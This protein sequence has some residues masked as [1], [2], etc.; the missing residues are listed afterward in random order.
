MIGS[1]VSSTKAATRI[2]GLAISLH[3][4]NRMLT[5][6][7]SVQNMNWAM[8]DEAAV[9]CLYIVYAGLHEHVSCVLTYHAT[10]YVLATN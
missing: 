6:V 8:T 7:S 5:Q 10:C 2:R 9:M 3:I 1:N 4:Y